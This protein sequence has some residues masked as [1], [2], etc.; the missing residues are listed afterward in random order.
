MGVI[1]ARSG[2]ESIPTALAVSSDAAQVPRPRHRLTPLEPE[3]RIE[4]DTRAARNRQD[5]NERSSKPSE[6]F[7]ESTVVYLI[8]IW[9]V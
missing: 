2:L 1:Y 3:D 7:G 8:N 5:E 6:S 9:T 4:N